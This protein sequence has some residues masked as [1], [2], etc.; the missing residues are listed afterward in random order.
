VPHKVRLAGQARDDLDAIWSY[1][2][3]QHG[4][5]AADEYVRSF[6]DIFARLREFP[7]I[8]V[9]VKGLRPASRSV[10]HRHYR[11]YYRLTEDEVEILTIVHGAR[12]VSR[13]LD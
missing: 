7:H 5:D 6:N 12:D 9:A 3:T 8:G 1:T 13:L 10:K 11:L 2:A 4:A